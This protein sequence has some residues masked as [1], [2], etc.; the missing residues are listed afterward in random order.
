MDICGCC[1]GVKGRAGGGEKRT[2]AVR[3]TNSTFLYFLREG[4]CKRLN[5]VNTAPTLLRKNYLKLTGAFFRGSKRVIREVKRV[6]ERG[7]E[8][9][10]DGGGGGGARPHLEEDQDI[11]GGD[12]GIRFA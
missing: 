7:W 3:F 4:V 11:A 8:G 10:R 9:G 5:P 1:E 2:R 6:R 12:E